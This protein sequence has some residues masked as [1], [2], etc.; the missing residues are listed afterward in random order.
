MP[1]YYKLTPIVPAMLMKGVMRW[2]AGRNRLAPLY[3]KKHN[4]KERIDAHFGSLAAWEALPGW[5]GT[6]LTRPSDTPALRP[7]SYDERKRPEELSLEDMRAVAASRGGKCLASELTPGDL[8]TLLE[9]KT[10]EGV[11][12]KG[13]PASIALGGHWGPLA[14][15]L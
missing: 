9:W 13:S 14:T 5:E 6:D 11:R 10:A 3:W 7:L 2:V 8:S 12:F 15:S 4:V 1:W